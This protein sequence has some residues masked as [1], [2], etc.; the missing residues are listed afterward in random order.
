MKT[1]VLAALLLALP[2]PAECMSSSWEVWPSIETKLPLNPRIVITGFGTVQ[3]D[4]EK[5]ASYGPALVAANHRVA[6]EVKQTNVGEMKISQAVL[7]PV[8]A[9]KPGLHY[10][11]AWKKTPPGF[12]Q[13]ANWNAATTRDDTAPTWKS[14]P[15][16]STGE[17]AELGCGPAEN[18]FVKLDVTDDAPTLI[19][20]RATRGNKTT[21]YLL[22]WNASE[23]LNIGHGMCS[24]A[25]QLTNDAWSLELSA[26]DVSG[27]ETPAPGGAIAFKYLEPVK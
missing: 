3:P 5:L 2:S 24:G 10:R 15:V 23:P 22:L 12:A 9:L 13:P 8:E 27:N 17:R 18:V 16:A 20:A 7:A 25:F 11:L 19:R 1:F 21:E 6:L 14:P 4:V 26:V